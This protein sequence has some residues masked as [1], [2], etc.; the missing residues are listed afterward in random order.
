MVE[1]AGEDNKLKKQAE[2]VNSCLH[3]RYIR[4]REREDEHR[5]LLV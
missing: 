2:F 4:E 3:G 1:V 5:I